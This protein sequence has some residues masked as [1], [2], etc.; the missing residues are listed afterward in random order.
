MNMYM[1]NPITDKG[2]ETHKAI[3]FQSNILGYILIKYTMIKQKPGTMVTEMVET[4]LDRAV[5]WKY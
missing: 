4:A 2:E 1:T 5:S 3:V